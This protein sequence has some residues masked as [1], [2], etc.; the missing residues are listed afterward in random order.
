LQRRHSWPR[1]HP[2]CAGANG[3]RYGTGRHISGLGRRRWHMGPWRLRPGRRGNGRS[4]GSLLPGRRAGGAVAEVR[5]QTHGRTPQSHA[6]KRSHP[7]TLPLFG[8]LACVLPIIVGCAVLI[9][10][11]H[12]QGRVCRLLTRRVRRAPRG[13][14]GRCGTP[15]AR[16]A[17]LALFYRERFAFPVIRST[18]I[19]ITPV[20]ATSSSLQVNAAPSARCSVML[21]RRWRLVAASS[22]SSAVPNAMALT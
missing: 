3:Y 20:L 21:S 22:T 14:A 12:M 16:R 9:T 5:F 8:Q 13:A 7:V 2:A 1:F 19:L 4:R 15:R 11:Q 18:R 10:A 17:G 6:R